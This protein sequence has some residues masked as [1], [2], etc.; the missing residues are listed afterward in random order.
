[1]PLS[2]F[3]KGLRDLRW[4]VFWY[5][6]GFALL[7]AL[8]VYVYPSYREQLADFDIPEAFEAFL[9]E[10]ADY[11]TAEGFLTAEFFSWAPILLVIF[12]IM[13]GTNMLAGEEAAGTMDLLLSQPLSRTRLLF[14]KLAAFVAGT[15]GIVLLTILG[16]ALSTP[17][18]DIEVSEVDLV[19]AT[20]N[21]M[22]ITLF[23][24]AF[25]LMASVS[26]P[27]RGQATG[28][29][30]ALAVATFML[31]YLASL[32]DLLEPLRWLSPFHYAATT[33]VLTNGMDWPK[34]AV[35]MALFAAFTAAAVWAFER[36][37]IGVRAAAGLPWSLPW[38]RRREAEPAG[39]ASEAASAP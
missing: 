38:G 32:V 6:L 28:V 5:G 20:L 3:G 1:M 37:D 15:L 14:E 10:S 8:V 12:A 9:G 17:F 27:S 4:Q 29:A 31:N 22:P 18:T 21:L 39:A 30:T 33:T 2:V 23:F 19:I 35:L 16:W 11:R 36:R 13:Q 26:L 34:V 7:A 25:S 24:G